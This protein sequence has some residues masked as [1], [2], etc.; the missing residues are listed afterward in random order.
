MTESCLSEFR[1]MAMSVSDVFRVFLVDVRRYER[2]F[3]VV[4][5]MLEMK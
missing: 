3:V 5:G 1:L 2:V 4:D